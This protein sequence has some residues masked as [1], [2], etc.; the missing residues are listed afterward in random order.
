MLAIM[1][2]FVMT[3]F[4]NMFFNTKWTNNGT[5]PNIVSA[6]SSFHTLLVIVNIGIFSLSNSSL[7]YRDKAPSIIEWNEF[8]I[9][10]IIVVLKM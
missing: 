3:D 10:I 4:A 6:S 8:L 7:F 1:N 9:R 2:F 5:T